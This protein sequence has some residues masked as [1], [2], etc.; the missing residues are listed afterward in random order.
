[1]DSLVTTLKGIL[2]TLFLVLGLGTTSVAAPAQTGD[3]ATVASTTEALPQKGMLYTIVKVVDGDTVTIWL[4]GR[5]Q[6]IRLIGINTPE[7]VD[8]RRPVQCFGKQ[9]SDKAKEL[10][11]G[12]QVRVVLDPSQGNYDK[13]HRMLG[14]I[15]RDDGF[16]L[17]EYMVK[18]GYAYEYTYRYPYQFQAAFKQAQKDAEA[19]GRGLWAPGVC[20]N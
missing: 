1:M 5:K 8:P 17:N 6:T 16:F 20:A 10:L 9:A 14:Y 19:H 7:T 13:Y 2:L 18:E 12:H 3:Q 15:Y 4:D 11:A